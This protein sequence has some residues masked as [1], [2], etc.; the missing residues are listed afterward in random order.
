MKKQAVLVVL[1]LGSVL[2]ASAQKSATPEPRAEI[3][4][5]YS[6]LAIKALATIRRGDKQLIAAVLADLD[7][8]TVDSSETY[9]KETQL[10]AYIG[11]LH[12][13][14]V[15]FHFRYQEGLDSE[16][17]FSAAAAREGKCISDWQPLLRALSATYPDS[18]PRDSTVPASKP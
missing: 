15:I 6:K 11:R 10:S 2:A 13:D 14:H 1:L 8:E 3:S 4:A 17:T 18:C 16:D 12:F 7:A 9:P 5:A